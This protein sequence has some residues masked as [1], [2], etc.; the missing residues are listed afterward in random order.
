MLARNMPIFPRAAHSD[1]R[2]D[3]EIRRKEKESFYSIVKL[4]AHRLPEDSGIFRNNAA[5][6]TEIN[7]S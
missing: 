1:E 4:R 2:N 6:P 3:K 7:Q 5:L